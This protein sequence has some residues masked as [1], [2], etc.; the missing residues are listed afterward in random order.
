MA[1]TDS[2]TQA[3]L[4]FMYKLAGDRV[5]P[6]L[7][8]CGEERIENLGARVENAQPNRGQVS[9]MIDWLK[10]FPFD[11]TEVSPVQQVEA[12]AVAESTEPVTPG[13]YEVDGTVYVVKYNRSKTRLY[14]KKLVEIDAH[15][16]NAAGEH[17]SIEFEYA[18]GAIYFIKAEHRMDVERAKELTI[19]Y[20]R[21]L[22]CGRKL[23]A[24]KS[25]E[26]GIGPVCIKAYR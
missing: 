5:V 4:D 2:P 10:S 3:Q 1:R 19:R 13:V 6:Q 21:C 7:G 12:E 25:V 17:V 23:K 20:A 8:T 26:Q 14:A 11:R 18:P 15:R 24:A 22:N 16:L 9:A